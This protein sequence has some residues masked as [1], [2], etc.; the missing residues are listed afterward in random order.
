ME[1]EKFKTYKK[2]VL[3]S[4]TSGA[5]FYYSRASDLEVYCTPDWEGKNGFVS[6]QVTD[7]KTGEYPETMDVPY[8][9]NLTAEKWFAIVKP[10]LDKY[11]LEVV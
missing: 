11:Q 1:T 7:F 10:F 5:I 3:D 8:E 6:I 9:G 4:C 2:W